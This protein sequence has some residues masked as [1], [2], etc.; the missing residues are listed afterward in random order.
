MTP[1]NPQDIH[2]P[3]YHF[4]PAANWMNDPNGVIQWKGRYHL[5]FQ[6][7]PDGAYHA[8]MHWGHAVSDDLAHWQELPIAIAPTPNSPGSGRHLHRLH[9]G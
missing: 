9:G 5:F 8:N 4:L 7:N 3:S 2:R 1:L 6:Y